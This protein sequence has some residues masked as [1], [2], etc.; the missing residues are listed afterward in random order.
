MGNNRPVKTK[1][2]IAF[3]T[4]HGCTYQRTKA[5]HDLYNCPNCFRPITH[6]EKDKEIPPLHLK[7]NLATMGFTLQYL[8]DWIDTNY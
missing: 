7:T 4:A 1:I 6:R 8:Y 2:W 3:L 5:S